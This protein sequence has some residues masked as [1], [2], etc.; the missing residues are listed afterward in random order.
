M[1]R[2]SSWLRD[3]AGGGFQCWL[4]LWARGVFL[5]TTQGREIFHFSDSRRGGILILCAV[6]SSSTVEQMKAFG[7]YFAPE[8]RRKGARKI[9]AMSA[10]VPFDGVSKVERRA[11]CVR[12]DPFH[13]DGN[14]KSS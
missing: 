10:C 14:D 9:F 5:P 6:T 7:G 1:L 2:T 4:P 8:R 3:S 11:S 12:L 13:P